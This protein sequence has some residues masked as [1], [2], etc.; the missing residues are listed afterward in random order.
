MSTARCSPCARLCTG[1]C[2]RARRAGGWGLRGGGSAAAP[3]GC[4]PGRS[5]G[6]RSASTSRRRRRTCRG[7]SRSRRWCQSGPASSLQPGRARQRERESVAKLPNSCMCNFGP[8]KGEKKIEKIASARNWV[9]CFFLNVDASAK[10]MLF[11]PPKET[12]QHIFGT[13]EQI[14]RLWPSRRNTGFV[15]KRASLL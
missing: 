1:S 14:S 10:S 2:R 4:R 5:R 13:K 7:W 12:L 9:A 6:R 3:A 15:I 8:R 11:S